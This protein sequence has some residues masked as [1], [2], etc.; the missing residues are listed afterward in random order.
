MSI[1]IFTDGACSKNGKKDAKAA[2]ACYFPDFPKLSTAE[3]VPDE[4]PQTNQRGELM[5]IA[6]S[7]EISLKSFPA[8]ETSLH[9]FTDSMYSKNCLTLWLPGWVSKD[10][11]TTQGHDVCHRDIIEKLVMDLSKFK[12]YS[13]SHVLAHTG[14]E[15]ENSKNN[16]I[17]DKMATKVLNPGETIKV[18]K[19]N[20]EKALVNFPLAL[21]GP[22]IAESTILDWCMKNLDQI[23]KKDLNTAL[24]TAL[25][26]TLK[27]KGFEITK[28]RLHRSTMLRLI[29]KTNLITEGSI[30]VKEE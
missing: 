13:I 26:K 18:I 9:I 15:D 22:P 5:A 1:R 2:W 27:K 30:I 11:K 3:R 21:M 20:T 10:W 12:S 7:V 24:L 17:V 25:S 19:S 23:D 14:N 29:S 8:S 4:D 16:D 6:R 28:Q